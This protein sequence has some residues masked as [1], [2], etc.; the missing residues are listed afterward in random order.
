MRAAEMKERPDFILMKQTDIQS[1]YYMQ[2]P[3]WL[4]SDP[5]YAE[6]SLEAKVTYTFLLNRFQLSRRMGWTNEQG[7]VFVIFP[8]KALAKELRICEQ[9]VTAA[10]RQLVGAKLIWEKRCGRGDA[11]Q[12]YLA[13]VDPEDDAGYEC[14][15][16]S[17]EEYEDGGS[18][19]ADLEVLNEGEVTREPQ[20]MGFQNRGCCGSRTSELEVP[21][22]QIPTPSKKEKREK[23]SV[24][25]EVSQSI[26]AVGAYRLTDRQDDEA[27]LIDILDACELSYF[28]P[29]TAMVFENAIERLFYSDSFRI[30]NATLPQS[31]VRRRLRRLDYMILQSAASKLAANTERDVKNSTAYTMATIFNAISES[32]SDLMVDPYLN[33]IGAPATYAGR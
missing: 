15:P 1:I 33:S 2:M 6:L 7:E 22:P 8:R 14:A 9:R 19:T 17:S 32:E 4:F 13:K 23:E 29:E 11:N 26:R 30:G 12:I 21:E 27:E 24:Q 10:F 16:F 18:R 25:K 28:P 5:R 31:R 3:R 20:E